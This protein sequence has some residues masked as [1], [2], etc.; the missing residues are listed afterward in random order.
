MPILLAIPFPAIDPVAVHLGPLTVRWYALA[1]M[2]GL[3]FAVWYARRLVSTPAL[4]AGKVPTLEPHEVDDLL[5]W[6]TLGVVLGGRIGY[7]LFYNLPHYLAHP[8]DIFRVWTGGMSFHGGFF[9][10]AVALYLFG[11]RREVGLDRLLDLAAPGVPVGLMLGRIANFINGELW[12]RPSDAPWAM[13]FPAGGDVPRHP[14]QLYEAA[15]EGVVLFIALRIATHRYH[16]LSKP[17]LVSAVFAIGYALARIVSEFF[18]QPDV[19]IGYLK[20]GLTM[21]M[22]LSL[23][24]LG[25]GIWLLVRARRMP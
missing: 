4:W 14:S 16:A 9:G 13:V 22:L 19:Q 25:I 15:L 12:G 10:V 3:I 23:P 1:Y 24:L 21:G 8:L 17:G 6:A 7:V 20:G 2:A 18:R 5:L 11:R